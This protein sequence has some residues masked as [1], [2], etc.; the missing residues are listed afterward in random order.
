MISVGKRLGQL[1]AASPNKPCL[2]C[3]SRKSTRR[4]FDERTNQLA[5]AFRAMGVKAGDLVAVALPNGSHFIEAVFAGLKLGATLL[6][7]SSKLPAVERHAVLDLAKPVLG[8]GMPADPSLPFPI[9]SNDFFATL[10]SYSADSLEDDAISKPP[11]GIMSGGSTG[12]PKIILTTDTGAI[13]LAAPPGMHI[14]PEDTVIIPGPLYHGMPFAYSY[15]TLLSGGHII[16]MERFDP[17]E[18]LASIERHGVRV[19][20]V[21]PTMMNRIWDLGEEARQSFD[22]RTLRMVVHSGSACPRWLKEHWIA[23]LGAERIHEFY[24]SSERIGFTWITGPEWLE[25]KGSVGRPYDSFVR[26]IGD[27]GQDLVAGEIGEIFMRN[28]QGGPGTT[29]R[30]IG[31]DP[32]RQHDGFETV[33][34]MGWLDADGYLYIADRRVDMIVTGG[35]NVF[36]AEVEAA[37]QRHPQISDCAVIGLPDPDLVNRVHAIVHAANDLDASDLRKWLRDQLVGYK[38]PRSFEFVSQSLRD[39]AGK[40]RRSQLRKERLEVPERQS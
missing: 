2:T 15:R 30:Y 16:V 1:A 26:I 29:Y 6:P 38:I 32:L 10:S 37:L 5:R 9:E 13:D 18:C 31:A 4:E 40:L 19:L 21:V 33:G 25:H 28:R 22:L 14:E 34:D 17:V 36:P 3:G 20:P 24:G 27:N 7:M 12:R 35:A 23:W 8:L 39:E 11:R